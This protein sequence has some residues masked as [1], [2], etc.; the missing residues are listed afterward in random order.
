MVFGCHGWEGNQYLSTRTCYKDLLHG[1]QLS[2]RHANV[3]LGSS[4]L[5]SNIVESLTVHSKVAS[6]TSDSLQIEIHKN[7]A[8]SFLELDTPHVQTG[9]FLSKIRVPSVRTR[10]CDFPV[11]PGKASK[12]G[13]HLS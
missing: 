7:L 8:P 11:V 13:E 5:F 6:N 2:D 12:H 4:Y 3:Q 10:Q 9:W 1:I